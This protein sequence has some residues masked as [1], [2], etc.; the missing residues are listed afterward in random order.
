MYIFK[1]RNKFKHINYRGLIG[2]YGCAYQAIL[3]SIYNGS[4]VYCYLKQATINA[5]T[6]PLN[7]PTV[8]LL[9]SR[10]RDDLHIHQPQRPYFFLITSEA[11]SAI[12]YTVACK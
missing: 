5:F 2:L 4:N 11:L 1:E 6:G 8:G 12:A 10:D 7:N 9:K 3:D